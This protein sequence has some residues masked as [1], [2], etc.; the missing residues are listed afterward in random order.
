MRGAEP[1]PGH[2]T[3]SMARRR[4][5]KER[6]G[7]SRFP[8]AKMVRPLRLKNPASLPIQKN[9]SGPDRRQPMKAPPGQLGTAEHPVGPG[10]ITPEPWV[11]G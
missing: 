1:C 6:P 10:S 9:G 8:V 11:E 5:S 4:R 3:G 7:L 2:D